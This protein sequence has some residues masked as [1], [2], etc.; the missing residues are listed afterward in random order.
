MVRETENRPYLVD[1][2]AEN[3]WRM[4]RILGE[5]AEG[6]E[7]LRDVGK[8]VTVFGSARDVLDPRAYA[9]AEAL[10]RALVQA[11]YAVLTGGG[12]GVMRAA[13]KGAFEAGGR[14]IGLNIELPHE[15]DPNPYQTDSVSFRY[16]FVRKVMLV[17]Y[18][19]AFVVFPG[20]FGT[21]DELF[22]S[23]TLI[24]TL[25]IHPFPVFLVGSAFWG[26]LVDWV[27][28][29]L[30]G[31]GTI[32]PEDVDLFR[33]VDEVDGIPALVD[34]YHRRPDHAGFHLPSDG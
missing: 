7:A 33:V 10:G 14:S 29:T 30:A 34:A 2:M 12:P 4:F 3:A 5:F 6:F 16:F 27:R 8:A 25:K 32:S 11:G 17:K 15:Q 13:N 18:A 23:L 24:Q 1:A 26:G 28:D 21:L 22:E 9:Q 20:G 19:S 31:Q